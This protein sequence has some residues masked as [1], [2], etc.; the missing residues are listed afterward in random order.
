MPSREAVAADALAHADPACLRESLA[1]IG[2]EPVELRETHTALVF[3]TGERAYKLKK[4][5]H[6]DFVDHRRAADRAAACHRE[7]A[8][9]EGLAP[10]IG[11][12]VRAVVPV[13]DGYELGD[14][15]DARA[16]DHVIE[17]RR[18]DEAQ[19]MRALLERGALTV[20][21]ARAAGA[22]IAPFHR[23][24]GVVREAI[25]HRALVHRNLEALVPLAAP[26][27]PPHEL[28][29]LERCA[30]AF[31][32]GYE[33][34]LSARARS[35]TIV[36]GHGDLRAEHV[37]FE[38]DRVLVVDRLE[39]DDLRR[40]DVADDLAFLLM[41][42]ESRGGG[43]FAEPVLDGYVRAGGAAPPAALLAFFGAYRAQVRAKVDLLRAG[44]GAGDV[45]DAGG[46]ARAREL[47]RLARR[48]GWRAR[49]PLILL[50]TGPPASGKSTLAAA[51]GRCSG[52]P[53]L[54]SD[55]ARRV[56][57]SPGHADYSLD[58][59]AR[60]YE[61]LAALAGS[62]RAVIIDATFGE[63]EL[64]HAFAAGLEASR[65]LLAIE[66]VASDDV[67]AGRARRRR[68]EGGSNSDAGPEVARE[69]GARFVPVGG[70]P[71]DAHLAVDTELPLE[72]QVDEVEAWLDTRLARGTGL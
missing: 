31:L 42:L 48:L 69:L 26:H 49:G 44:Q 8:L 24:A 71:D 50:V 52:L 29:A 23:R 40:V 4:P 70:L 3:L 45:P 54:S 68:A 59:R 62:T 35:G 21:Q 9:N 6:F 30:D 47:L 18:F 43:N 36:D 7:L 16:V 33:D 65:P 13:Q 60:V 39:F 56:A 12:A 27:V 32:L 41:D 57:G 63:P 46:A 34:V 22:A 14:A 28:L 67:R 15:G 2:G 25:D 17:M 19:T 1:R 10:G 55:T 53:V 61:Q 51:L 66:C 37:L 20:E 64:Q 72:L 58:A 5:V 11:I 38:G